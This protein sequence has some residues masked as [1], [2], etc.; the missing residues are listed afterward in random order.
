M[1]DVQVQRE[2][3]FGVKFLRDQLIFLDIDGVLNKY[4]TGRVRIATIGGEPVAKMPVVDAELVD[5]L[6][7]LLRYSRAN[8]VLSTSWRTT[9]TPAQLDEHLRAACSHWPFGLIIGA[10]PSFGM[11]NRGTEI[12]A[13]LRKSKCTDYVI[14][15]DMMP[16]DFLPHQRDRLIQ[17]DPAEGFDWGALER[18]V[19]MLKTKRKV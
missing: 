7:A 13:Y 11:A 16:H 12:D 6:A 2:F 17:T 18:A 1:K 5:H 10:T 14:I 3:S 19:S 8:V 9:V 15:D 4:D